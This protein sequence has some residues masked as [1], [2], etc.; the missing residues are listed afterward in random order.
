MS[1]QFSGRRAT[2][3]YRR[4]VNVVTPQSTRIGSRFRKAE[5]RYFLTG[6]RMNPFKRIDLVVEAFRKLPNERLVV[7]G[8]GPDLPKIRRLAGP[9]VELVGRLTDCEVVHA[10]QN[11]TAF[12]HAAKEDFGIAMAEAQSCGTPVSSR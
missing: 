12:V 8:D 7:M 10:M 2:K 9:N 4:P 3:V 1:S 11:A 6:S 5:D